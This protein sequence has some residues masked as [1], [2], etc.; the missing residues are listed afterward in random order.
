MTS[1]LDRLSERERQAL[2]LLASGHDG[3]SIAAALDISV[4]TVNERLREARRKIGVSSSREAARL[5]LA[6]EGAAESS[7]NLGHKEIRVGPTAGDDIPEAPVG[8]EG[9]GRR[10]AILFVGFI[11]MTIA[12]LAALLAMQPSGTEQPAAPA[13]LH[14]A[15]PLGSLAKLFLPE[16]YPRAALT[17]R[18]QG[19]VEFR[20]ELANIVTYDPGAHVRAY[21]HGHAFARARVTKCEITRSSGNE[22]L[23]AATCRIIRSR[24]RFV[25]AMNAAE[26]PVAGEYQGYI[27]W[28]LPT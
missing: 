5:L 20:V 1:G 8:G 27:D 19:R 14:Q 10:P 23:D 15:K 18:A 25:P 2:R 28:T 12:V 22:A 6:W 4:H 3:K 7:Q 24:S 9:F 17:A 16:D 26:Q 11:I 21:G 13:L